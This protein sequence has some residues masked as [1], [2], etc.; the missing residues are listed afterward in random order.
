MNPKLTPVEQ[1]IYD[2]CLELDDFTNR[3]VADLFDMPVAVVTARLKKVYDKG[4]YVRTRVG[5]IRADG[6]ASAPVHYFHNNAK[7]RKKADKLQREYNEVQCGRRRR[8]LQLCQDRGLLRE[9]IAELEEAIRLEIKKTGGNQRL[10]A[11]LNP[12]ASQ[13]PL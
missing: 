13:E 12:Q 5:A 6:Y 8:S 2:Q 4:Y 10:E 9:R 7:N 11:A 1:T 3:E